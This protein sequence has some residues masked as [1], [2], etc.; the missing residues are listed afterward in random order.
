MLPSTIQSLHMFGRS[1][2]FTVRSVVHCH[3]RTD[4]V[5]RP[6]ILTLLAAHE[7]HRTN[8]RKALAAEHDVRIAQGTSIG[9]WRSL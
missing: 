2:E 8:S 5:L 4:Q 9:S 1:S 7:H 3:L 6:S